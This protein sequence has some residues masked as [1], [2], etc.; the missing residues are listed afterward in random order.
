[1]LLSPPKGVQFSKFNLKLV[2]ENVKVVE[3][4]PGFRDFLLYSVYREVI[5]YFHIRFILVSGYF[6]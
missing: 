2:N 1:M 4:G 3:K 5:N 6:I